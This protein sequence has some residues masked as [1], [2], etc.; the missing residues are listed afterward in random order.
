MQISKFKKIVIKIGSST[1]VDKKGMPKKLWLKRFKNPLSD[2][3]SFKILYWDY[4][5]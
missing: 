2:L 4:G 5:L 1:L 3:E